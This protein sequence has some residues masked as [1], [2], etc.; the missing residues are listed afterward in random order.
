MN[1]ILIIGHSGFVE[2]GICNELQ[3][4]DSEF[5]GLTSTINS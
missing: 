5:I 2:K 4:N 1:K 3:V